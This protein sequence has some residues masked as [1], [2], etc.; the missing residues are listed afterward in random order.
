MHPLRLVETIRANMIWGNFSFMEIKFGPWV[1]N[2][3]PELGLIPR[4]LLPYGR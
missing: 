1:F 3:I 4:H 2:F